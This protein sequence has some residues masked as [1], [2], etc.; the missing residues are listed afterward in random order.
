MWPFRRKKSFFSNEEN[1]QIVQSI[2][3]AERQTSGELRIFVESRCKY[4]DPLDRAAELFGKLQMEKTAL[5]NGV[6]FYVAV[7]DKQLAIFADTGIHAA[8]GEQYWKE[9]VQQILSVFSKESVSAG[10]IASVAKIGD[11]LK[12]NFPYDEA[13]DKNEL[14][15]E[16]IFGQ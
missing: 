13:V 15:D 16:I 5:R 7:T 2:K 10:I 1:E 6:L 8:A 3:N 11:A 14:P 9:S 12:T 4:V